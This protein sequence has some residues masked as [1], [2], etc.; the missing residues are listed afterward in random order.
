MS[1]GVCAET[2]GASPEPVALG[3]ELAAVAGLAV[4]N[5]LVA[6]LVRRVQHLVAHAALE[7]LLMKRQLPDRPSLGCVYG[8]AAS[9][10]LDLL[11]G[12]EGHCDDGRVGG[13]EALRNGHRCW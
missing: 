5:S 12:L 7:A 2:S 1:S 3:P 6:V 4:E 11:G 10:A 9:R 13:A 8:L